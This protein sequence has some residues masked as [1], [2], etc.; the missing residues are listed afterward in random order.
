MTNLNWNDVETESKGRRDSTVTRAVIEGALQ[1]P[2]LSGAKIAAALRNSGV[3]AK[4]G[5]AGVATNIARATVDYLV[6]NDAPIKVN[7]K[8]FR[9]TAVTATPEL[10]KREDVKNLPA[11]TA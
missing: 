6:S 11:K 9:L 8:L 4:D 10:V 3:D 2:D 7:G 1:R 5:Y